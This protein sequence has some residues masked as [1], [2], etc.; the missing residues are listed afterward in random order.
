MSTEGWSSTAAWDMGIAANPIVV[1]AEAWECPLPLAHVLRLGAVTY[2]TRD[3]VVVR[4]TTDDGRQGHAV[5]YTRHTPLLAATKTVCEQ[6]PNLGCDPVQVHEAL[7][8]RFAPGWSA[9]VRAASLIDVALWDLRSQREGVPLARAL[10]YDPRPVP[11][12]AVAGYF[13]D[14]R[15][16]GE[17]LDE[18]DR[19]VAEGYSTVKL[20]L[21]GHNAA[22]DYDLV[23]KV[24][25]RT[26][27]RVAIGVDFHGA[28]DT[29][30]DALVHCE[31]LHDLGLRFLEDPF[32]S[33]EW[34]EVR[35]FAAVSSTPVAAGEDLPGLTALMDLLDNGVTYL[36]AD[37]TASGGYSVVRRAMTHAASLDAKFV[38][39]VWPHIH[40]PL[41]AGAP[42]G[43]PVEVIPDYVGADP[44]WLLLTEEPPMRDGLWH[45]PT[46]SGLF[47]PL[48]H[49]AVRKYSTSCFTLDIVGAEMC[50]R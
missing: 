49:D 16:T 35:D 40:A 17:Q 28:F 44:V 5:G 47:L 29:V 22:A 14:R 9:L 7:R 48:D 37:V 18:I 43:S 36:R 12:M 24:R 27:E 1:R 13:S 50:M 38:P 32:P 34:H 45:P 2:A 6:L 21:P 39:H 19:F 4:L 26:P 15:S 25:A 31:R 33:A 42:D 23:K 30:P 11:A 8:R 46:A 3:Y 41:V 10:G 20:I